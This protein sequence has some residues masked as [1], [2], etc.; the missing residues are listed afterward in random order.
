VD[1]PRVSIGQPTERASLRQLSMLEVTRQRSARRNGKGET[2][3]PS[4]PSTVKTQRLRSS[5]VLMSSRFP[6][7]DP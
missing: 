2:L 6:M 3:R 1:R 7:Q 4:Y 5:S